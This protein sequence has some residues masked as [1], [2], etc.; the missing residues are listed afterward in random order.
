MP[1]APRGE[2]DPE[3]I[4]ELTEEEREEDPEDTKEAIEWKTVVG[5]DMLAGEEE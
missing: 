2:L 5:V 4:G 3:E 1:E